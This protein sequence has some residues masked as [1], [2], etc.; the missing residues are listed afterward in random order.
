MLKGGPGRL[1][2]GN[3]VVGRRS[4]SLRTVV[5]RCGNHRQGVFQDGHEA[6]PAEGSAI[7]VGED[8]HIGGEEGCGHLPRGR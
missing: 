7:G 4:M 1:R 2:I 8:G 6:A 3:P 5:G